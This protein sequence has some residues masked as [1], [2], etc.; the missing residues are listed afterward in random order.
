MYRESD[1]TSDTDS[2]SNM[3]NL[4]S[5]H[6]LNFFV[7][8]ATEDDIQHALLDMDKLIDDFDLNVLHFK[9]YGT[10]YIKSQ[11]L[12]PDSFVQMAMQYAFYR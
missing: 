9:G 10:N 7:S 1:V 11:N 8:K 3:E 5:P 12:S 6:K 4:V 2:E